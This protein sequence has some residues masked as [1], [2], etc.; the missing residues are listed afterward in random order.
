MP[1]YKLDIIVNAK[2]NA[3]R[4]LGGLG[5]TLGGLGKVAGIG[6]G[7]AAAAAVGAGVVI[8][9]VTKDA[10]RVATDFESQMSILAIAAKSSGLAFDGLEAAALKVGGDISLIGV[11]AS[12]SA[13]AMTGL[14]KA[15]L[16]T[17]E[18]F[19]DL[20]GYM[21]GTAKLGGALR[22]SIDLAAASELDMV[23]ASDL[24]AIALSTFGGELKTEEERAEFVNSA[25]NNMVKAADASVASV[26]DLAGALS[27]IGP[28][29]SAF[30]F[31]FEEMN[32]AL[33]LLSTRGIKG[34]E[35]GTSLKSMLTNM[36]RPT[37]KTVGA[38]NELGIS[39]Y[40]SEGNMRSLS[41]IVGQF[42]TSMAG[43]TEEQK[44]AY[45]QQIA[46]TY[47]MKALQTLMA[48]GVEGWDAMAKATANASGI[49]EQAAAKA[50]TLAG[51][52]EALAGAL[53]TLKITAS[54]E[55]LPILTDLTR[56]AAEM[57]TKYGPTVVA[58]VGNIAEAFRGFIGF[59]SGED[60][61]ADWFVDLVEKL[62]GWLQP[63]VG[64][65]GQLIAGGF[66]FGDMLPPEALVLWESF[67]RLLDTLGA[68]WDVNGPAIME[69]AR[70]LGRV[71]KEAFMELAERVLPWLAEKLDQFGVWWTENGPLIVAFV[72]NVA[73]AIAIMAL[74][75][76]NMWIFVKP[77]LDL[78]LGHIALIAKMIMQ[79]A[80]GDWAG[81]WQTM[82]DTVSNAWNFIQG[83]IETAIAVIMVA[84]DK[85]V[86][87]I[88]GVKLPSWLG[89]KGN[90][91][92]SE[93]DDDGGWGLQ[94]GGLASGPTIVGEMGP[95]LLDAMPGSR[96][97]NNQQTRNVV[98]NFNQTVNTRATSPSVQQDYRMMQARIPR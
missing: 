51:A 86:E 46:G 47:G 12:G 76:S 89:G 11:S 10:I 53:E 97:Y 41:N 14:Y 78:L 65:I 6:F 50:N 83:V 94:H 8:T 17:T 40:D 29:A 80:T 21:A 52:Q 75:V 68:W 7:V 96:V 92:S 87:K 37:A 22:A 20:D 56:W 71:L 15:G 31:S 27:V 58:V 2:D 70:Q 59:L 5:R 85:L 3:S 77:V 48:E 49:E 62:P 67:Q 98:N 9:K 1:S 69:S 19:G 88:F 23:Q 93:S 32:N 13:D 84:I 4:V 43:M 66:S 25:M 35:A 64:L 36:M 44:N 33:A 90:Q 60:E 28:T 57:V 63:I 95:E 79:L 38:M 54:K 26:S 24:A 74:V 45:V 18:I 55:L 81:A 34:A 82:Q 42:T 72:D 30:G 73:K 16:T 61:Y 39:L 91:E